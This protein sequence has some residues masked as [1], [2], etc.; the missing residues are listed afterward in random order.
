MRKL[1]L[2]IAVI[3]MAM[4][5]AWSQRNCGTME[6]LQMQLQQDPSLAQRI[7]QHMLA[8]YL[9]ITP[10]TL[11]RIRKSISQKK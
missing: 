9:G 11:S 5:S 7:P 4:T 10:E 3:C 2:L 6:H 1:L 8:S